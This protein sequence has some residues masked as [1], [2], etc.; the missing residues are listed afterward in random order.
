MKQPQPQSEIKRL[1]L[2][3]DY[4]PPTSTGVSFSFF[5]FSFVD[6]YDVCVGC[7]EV[8]TLCLRQNNKSTI[9]TINTRSIIFNQQKSIV[10][11]LTHGNQPNEIC[12]DC[13]C[14]F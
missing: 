3:E 2:K 4:T 14:L 8:K 6:I 5:F 12:P 1:K 11:P 9:N 7:E 13:K 10:V